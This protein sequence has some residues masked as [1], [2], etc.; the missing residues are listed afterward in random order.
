ML[1]IPNHDSRCNGVK[2]PDY[3]AY[4]LTYGSVSRAIIQ[5]AK[6]GWEARC[7]LSAELVVTSGDHL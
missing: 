2:L 5:P 6:Y 7:E 1:S 3:E 4:V